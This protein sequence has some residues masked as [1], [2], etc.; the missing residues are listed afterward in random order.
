MDG[1]RWYEDNQC[2]YYEDRIVLPEAQLDGC[3]GGPISALGTQGA[4][5]LLTSSGSAS[6]PE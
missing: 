2:L 5:G 3:L 1:D 4:T 6:T